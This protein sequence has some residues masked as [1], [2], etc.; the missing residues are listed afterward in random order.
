MKVI[1]HL[2]QIIAGVGAAVMTIRGEHFA[3]IVICLLVICSAL[4]EIA[5]AIKALKEQS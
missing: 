5:N 3:A 4:F 1:I 2:G